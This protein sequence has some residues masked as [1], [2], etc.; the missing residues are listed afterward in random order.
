MKGPSLCRTQLLAG[1]EAN[2]LKLADYGMQSITNLSHG[3]ENPSKGI[4]SRQRNM[5]R[6]GLGNPDDI[7]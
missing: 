7:S 3:Q 6:Y 2:L 4:R 5:H 1:L